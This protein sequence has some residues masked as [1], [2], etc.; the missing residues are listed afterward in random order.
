MQRDR[1]RSMG[2]LVGRSGVRYGNSKWW[3]YVDARAGSS[4]DCGG[5]RGV[6][7]RRE[8]CGAHQETGLRRTSWTLWRVDPAGEQHQ[9]GAA[10]HRYESERAII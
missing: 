2:D 4:C 9:S 7:H 6:D 5:G 10:V 3:A 1:E 8:G